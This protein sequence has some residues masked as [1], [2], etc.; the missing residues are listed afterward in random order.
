MKLKIV[1]LGMMLAVVA[2][3]ANVTVRAAAGKDEVKRVG[4]ATAVLNEMMRARDKAIPG[5][6]WKK[7]KRLRSYR[8]SR[9]PVSSSADNGDAASSVW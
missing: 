6:I 2:I 5:S 1:A 3:G 9:K 4:A 8:E 7:P